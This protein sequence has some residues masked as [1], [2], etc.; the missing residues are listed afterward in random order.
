MTGIF[1]PLQISH[2]QRPPQ[3]GVPDSEFIIYFFVKTMIY[4]S[5]K[6]KLEV[7]ITYDSV[8]NSTGDNLPTRTICGFPFLLLR[9]TG[10]SLKITF[11]T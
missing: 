5:I 1:D 2:H 9:S 3:V 4:A 11:V 8:W 6:A 7:L 10:K